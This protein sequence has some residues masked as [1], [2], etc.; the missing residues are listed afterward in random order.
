MNIWFS[1]TEVWNNLSS[2]W[3]HLSCFLAF[4]FCKFA[5]SPLCF[6]SSSLYNRALK[7]SQ[8]LSQT[9]WIHLCNSL[10]DQLPQYLPSPS[11]RST[12]TTSCRLP[13]GRLGVPPTSGSLQTKTVFPLGQLLFY[14]PSRPLS[15]KAK[16]ASPVSQLGSAHLSL[17]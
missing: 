11:S 16:Y 10:S 7:A 13:C 17:I 15:V 2:P 1:C 6:L 3:S 5:I 12:S 4:T 8:R 9:S 14:L